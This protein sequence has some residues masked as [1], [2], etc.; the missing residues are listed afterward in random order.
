MTA[1]ANQ[2]NKV[3][4]KDMGAIDVIEKPINIPEFLNKINS[5]LGISVK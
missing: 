4:A 2:E 3:I 1:F 5:A